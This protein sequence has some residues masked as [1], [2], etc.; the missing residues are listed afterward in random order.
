MLSN[1]LER[2][3]KT[4]AVTCLR[5]IASRARYDVKI[6]SVSVKCTT[7]RAIH[8][9]VVEDVTNRKSLP[10]KL[11]SDNASTFLSAN[12]E[13]K[14]LFESHALKETLA[15]EGVEWQFIPKRA[16][17]YGVFLGTSHLSHQIHH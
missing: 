1:A 6:L 16:P 17:W 15:R 4:K 14:E 8:L 7:T 10:R 12:N 5:S 3:N 11:I 13:L 9:E 2:S